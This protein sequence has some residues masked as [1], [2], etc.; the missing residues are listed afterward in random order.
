[1]KSEWMGK[2]ANEAQMWKNFFMNAMPVKGN[3]IAQGDD[4]KQD[5][6]NNERIV[7]Q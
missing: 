5:S 1:M 3:A 2:N 7:K 6:G 4:K